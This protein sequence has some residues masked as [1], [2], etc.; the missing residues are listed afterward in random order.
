MVRLAVGG[1]TAPHPTANPG[2]GARAADRPNSGQLG[3][4]DV[5]ALALHVTEQPRGGIAQ[6]G[7]GNHVV[8]LAVLQQELGGLEPVREVLPDGLLD[9]PLSGKADYGARLSQDHIALHGKRGRDAAG[10]GIG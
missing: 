8:N 4:L 1:T 10:S 3:K 2:W 7:A 5:R 9:Y 6:R